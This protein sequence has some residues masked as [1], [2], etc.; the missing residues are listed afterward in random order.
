[1]HTF[2]LAPIGFD[3]GLTSISLGLVRAL[4]QAGL[5]VGFVKP[6]SQEGQSSEDEHSTHFARAICHTQ[7]PTPLSLE[8]V[9]RLLC[10]NRQHQLVD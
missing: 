2:F 3:T 1:M 10:R 8:H 7:S 4:A 5:R 6:I 9:E